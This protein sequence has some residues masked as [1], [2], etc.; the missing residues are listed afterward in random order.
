[1]PVRVKADWLV[2]KETCIPESAT[3][4]AVLPSS[5]PQAQVLLNNSKQSLPST[6]DAEAQFTA[7]ADGVTITLPADALGVDGTP[8]SMQWLP[9]EDGII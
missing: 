4:E 7:T 6:S 3:L 8:A 1:G 5:N 2:C 9:V